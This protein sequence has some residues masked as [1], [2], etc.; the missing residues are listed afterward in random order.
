MIGG[1]DANRITTCGQGVLADECT[2]IHSIQALKM[3]KKSVSKGEIELRTS[4]CPRSA[5]E[6]LLP[7][8][9]MVRVIRV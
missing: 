8:I 9:A 1:V 5:G 2:S 4:M 7:W 3:H 6:K